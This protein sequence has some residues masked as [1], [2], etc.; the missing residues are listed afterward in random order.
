MLCLP[1]WLWH[2]GTTWGVSETLM[3]RPCPP[4]SGVGPR[5]L[6]FSRLSGS[7]CICASHLHSPQ[8]P[9]SVLTSLMLSRTRT[10]VLLGRLRLPNLSIFPPFVSLP[11]L[12]PPSLPARTP[13]TCPLQGLVCD[14]GV[15]LHLP[16]LCVLLPLGPLSTPMA[17]AAPGCAP[18]AHSPIPQVADS[19]WD[20]VVH[21]KAAPFHHPLIPGPALT[22]VRLSGRD[23]QQ[24]LVHTSRG[25]QRPTPSWLLPSSC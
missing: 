6:Y 24:L 19:L 16:A 3:L 14:S 22:T 20:K 25:Q 12:L 9:G 1:P 2:A 7:N 17:P 8:G 18:P 5:H 23:H 10:P 11:S 21:S 13:S 4:H 15:L